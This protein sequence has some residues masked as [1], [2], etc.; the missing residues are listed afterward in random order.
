MDF[1]LSPES[2]GG[3]GPPGSGHSVNKSTVGLGRGGEER[4]ELERLVAT[5]PGVIL[6]S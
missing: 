3:E 5:G 4:G 1:C 6:L 2:H